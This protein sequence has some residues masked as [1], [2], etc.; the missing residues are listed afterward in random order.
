MWLLS[1]FGPM[2]T[3]EELNTVYRRSWLIRHNI[4]SGETESFGIPLEGESWPYHGYEWERGLLF[5]IG[6]VKTM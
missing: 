2:P 5:G 6:S 1:Y 3:K 4:F